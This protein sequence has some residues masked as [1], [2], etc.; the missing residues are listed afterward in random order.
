MVKGQTEERYH[1]FAA[2]FGGAL[3]DEMTRIYNADK[4]P[5]KNTA[6]TACRPVMCAIRKASGLSKLCDKWITTG[7]CRMSDCQGDHPDWN[8]EWNGQW[9]AT[10]CPEL[11]A[12]AKVPPDWAP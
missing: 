8:T 6:K 4:D 7:R 10:Y 11:T 1:P 2:Q 9:L 5:E 12:M 3:R